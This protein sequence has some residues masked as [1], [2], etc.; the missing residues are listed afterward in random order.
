MQRQRPKRTRMISIAHS[1]YCE[2]ARW[3]LQVAGVPFVD[4][5]FCFEYDQTGRFRSNYF[6][7]SGELH[8]REKPGDPEGL[9]KYRLPSIAVGSFEGNPQEKVQR[10][11]AV[12]VPCAEGSNGELLLSSFEIAAYASSHI[13]RFCGRSG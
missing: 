13:T 1:H 5:L 9:R 12:S 3:A 7:P 2:G 4:E 11:L 8:A 6:K 10:R